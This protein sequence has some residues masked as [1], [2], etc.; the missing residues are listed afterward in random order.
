MNG[1]LA[2]E[3]Q[4]AK[5]SGQSMEEQLN[6]TLSTHQEPLIREVMEL[7]AAGSRGFDYHNS[8][9]TAWTTGSGGMHERE[10][11][12]VEESVM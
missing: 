9:G 5:C 11:R 1:R 3:L 6:Q 12:Q 8:R 10:A 4:R 7:S 2:Q